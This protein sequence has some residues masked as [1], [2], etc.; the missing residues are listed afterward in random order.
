[1]V[2]S[3][4]FLE[5]SSICDKKNHNKQRKN[6]VILLRNF[7][8]A[9]YSNLNFKNI[10]GNKKFWKTTKSCFSHKSINFENISLT[11]NGKLLINNF[12]KYL[13]EC[14]QNLVPKL[15]IKLAKT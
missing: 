8:K 15:D 4:K 13:S 6:C 2:S 7:T 14:F 9:C 1:M 3:N 5:S 12:E 10:S 11:K